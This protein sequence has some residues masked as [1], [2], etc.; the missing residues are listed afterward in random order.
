MNFQ[1]SKNMKKVNNVFIK[2]SASIFSSKYFLTDGGLETTMIY[3]NN[4]TLPHFAAF[5]LVYTSQGRELLKRY[6]EQFIT[7]AQ[8]YGCTYILETPTWRANPDWGY[9]LGY[10]AHELNKANR[11]AVLFM[12]EIQNSF[13]HTGNKIIISGCVGPRGDGYTSTN[14]MSI[15]EASDYHGPQIRTFAL[16]DV[17]VITAM[18]LNY[19]EEAIGIVQ[20][21][22][23]LGVPVVISFTV[24]TNG[25]LPSGESL[26]EAIQKV[27]AFTE[28]Y[29]QHFMINCAH[30]E[31]FTFTLKD[32]S[33][34]K[35]RI[36]G[37][38]ANA[39]TK[40][41]AELDESTSLDVGDRH[42]L[43]LGYSE[44]KDSLPELF[45]IG[46]CCGTDHSHLEEICRQLFDEGRNISSLSA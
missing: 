7:L 14:R 4:I 2:E 36:R 29:A 26:K 9:K 1:N 11:H 27:D 20:A 6:H 18:T 35:N 28:N 23:T 30:P 24:E 13:D 37:I 5:E 22:K 44:L 16:A 17:D 38:R 8:R 45:V 15:V 21:A 46:G 3:H 33:E 40:S 43:A 19:S 41:H 39:S 25:L 34:W 12:R 32:R 31:H 10:D 42:K